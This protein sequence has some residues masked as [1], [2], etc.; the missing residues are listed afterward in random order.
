MLSDLVIAAFPDSDIPQNLDRRIWFQ[1]DGAPPYH[2]VNVK[3]FFW[4][5]NL[6][7]SELE[8]VDQ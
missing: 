3:A 7:E 1:R 4:S 8:G 2:G 6:M 5:I